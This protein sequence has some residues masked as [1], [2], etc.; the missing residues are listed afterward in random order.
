MTRKLLLALAAVVVLAAAGLTGWRVLRPAELSEPATTPYP[1]AQIRPAGVT[2]KLTQAPLVVD[3]TIR[4]YAGPRVVK[5]DAPVGAKTMYTPR[6]SYRRWPQQLTGIVAAGTTV[7]S[8][9]SDGKLV[10]LDGRT[11]KVVW[12]FDGPAATPV[13]GRTGADAVWA[14]A[15]LFTHGNTVIMSDGRRATAVS[16]GTERW[17]A[18]CADAFVTAGGALVCS[19]GAYD[20]ATGKKVDWPAGP[21]AALGCDVA[22]SGCAG[23]RDSAGQ[24]WLASGRLVRAPALDSPTATAGGDLV[25]DTAGGIVT[26][27]GAATWRWTGTAQVLGVRAGKVVLLTSAQQ[28]VTLDAAT[29]AE[30]TAFPLYVRDE[31]KEPWKPHLWQVTDSFVAIERLWPEATGDPDEVK[32]YYG[33]D[34]VIAAAF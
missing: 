23:L 10:A 31:R 5:A 27:S 4:V 3:G 18:D 19:G 32:H 33:I 7:V 21:Y 9:W 2:G 1:V 17:S 14:P 24:G 30:L 12:R 22:R 34:P 20:V 28:L 26:A 15:G 8:R 6:W 13:E 29:G 25:L 16:E 11:G